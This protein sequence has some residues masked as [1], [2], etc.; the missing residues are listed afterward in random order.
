[1]SVE[2]LSEAGSGGRADETTP[3]SGLGLFIVRDIATLYGGDVALGT[4]PFWRATGCRAITGRYLS[5]N[6]LAF[7]SLNGLPYA[8]RCRRHINIFDTDWCQRIH[9]RVNDSGWRPGGATFACALCA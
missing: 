6:E 9:D 3:G 8:E 7:P 1:L 4:A 2:A 5:K